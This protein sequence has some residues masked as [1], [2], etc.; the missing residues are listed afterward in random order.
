MEYFWLRESRETS[1]RI[2]LTRA[3]IRFEAIVASLPSMPLA[4]RSYARQL[5]RRRARSISVHNV[6]A[7]FSKHADTTVTKVHA[8]TG[9]NPVDGALPA[10][11][12]RWCVVERLDPS[13]LVQ[14]SAGASSRRSTEDSSHRA[15]SRWP[16]QRDGQGAAGRV[17]RDPSPCGGDRARLNCPG[18]NG[19]CPGLAPRSGPSPSRSR[20]QKVGSSFWC[21]NPREMVSSSGIDGR[22]VFGG[23]PTS[24]RDCRARPYDAR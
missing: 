1:L 12:G 14:K 8:A 13:T 21:E 17:A 19:S 6:P 7:Q 24:G 10:R 9:F 23:S 20:A 18:K 3:L 11:R 22:P 4:Q 5:R 15:A 16:S 2:W